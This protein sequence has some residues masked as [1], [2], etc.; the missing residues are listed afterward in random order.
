MKCYAA[1]A[2]ER[3]HGTKAEQAAVLEYNGIVTLVSLA[4]E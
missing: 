2:Q 1:L 3:I 4:V